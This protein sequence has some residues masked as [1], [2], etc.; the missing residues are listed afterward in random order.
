MGRSQLVERR[1]RFDQIDHSR[2]DGCPEAVCLTI[3]FPNYKLFFSKRESFRKW[4][5][6]EQNQWVVLLL[7][8][9]LLWELDCAFCIYN[10]ADSNVAG[11]PLDYRRKPEALE[12]MFGDLAAFKRPWNFP[13]K[14]PTSPQAE[15][16]V[17]DVVP[18]SNLSEIHFC[19]YNALENWSN[20]H[21]TA[22]N[23]TISYGDRYFRRRTFK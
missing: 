14:H 1:I 9:R 17:F 13:R 23:A 16:L 2:Q 15:V 6:V 21:S 12:S 18:I 4:Y 11:L 7:E 5:G 3:S 20:S 19:D 22:C 10:A 8:A